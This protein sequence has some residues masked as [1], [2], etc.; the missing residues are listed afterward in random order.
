MATTAYLQIDSSSSYDA[1]YY[2][3]R[4]ASGA[5]YDQF[6]SD[7]SSATA[8]AIDTNGMLFE[9]STGYYAWYSDAN[10]ISYVSFVD[11]SEAAELDYDQTM[12]CAVVAQ[13]DGSQQLDCPNGGLSYFGN[14]N[15]VFAVANAAGASE[16]SNGPFTI[17]VVVVD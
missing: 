8:Y 2:L 17:N 13:T 16:L 11:A 12:S 7:E 6:T 15:S 10:D 5:G 1:G 9:V 4:S 3:L 14:Y